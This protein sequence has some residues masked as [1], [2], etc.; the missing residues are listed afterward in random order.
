MSDVR[1]VANRLVENVERVIVGK[2]GAVELTVL[3]L[4]CQGHILIEDVPGVGKTV[5]YDLEKGKETLRLNTLLKILDAL[6]ISV[7]LD[8]PA[9][10]RFEGC[11]RLTNAAMAKRAPARGMVKK[12]IRYPGPANSAG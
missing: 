6:N 5:I 10:D 9:M 7:S 1:D 2:R 12:K 11:L 8:G 4:L 3:G